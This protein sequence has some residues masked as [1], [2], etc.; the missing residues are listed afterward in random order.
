M[1]Q[2][3]RKAF[4]I[5]FF[6]AIVAISIT[7]FVMRDRIGQVSDVGYLGLFLLCFLANSTVLLPAPSLMIAASCAL[8]MNPILVSLFA[9]LGST[10]G[11]FVG[12]AFGRITKDLS[13][14][15]QR[16][17][18]KLTEKVH[19]DTL[20]VFILAVLPLPL[21]DVVGIYS[22]GTKMNLGKFFLACFIGK[23]IKLLIYTRI[24]DVVE[25]AY[26]FYSGVFS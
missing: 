24:Y 20:L 11:E 22:G 15:F 4:E 10:L 17:L 19:S 13:P 9:A 26:S 5:L 21:F 25:W 3:L 12:Y 14:K 1:K 8:I 2:K 7:I 18:G 16:F 6:V 23:F